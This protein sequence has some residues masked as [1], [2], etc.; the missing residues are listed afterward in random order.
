MHAQYLSDILLYCMCVYVVYNII[1]NPEL[2]SLP[3]SHRRRY[4]FIGRVLVSC[5]LSSW[6]IIYTLYGIAA[7]STLT[8]APL[9]Q[10]IAL[11]TL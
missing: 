1:Q 5:R 11:S 9:R 2:D 3:L 8:N 10:Q 4:R 6:I 7:R